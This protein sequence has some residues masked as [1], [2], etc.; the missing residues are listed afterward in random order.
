LDLNG[1]MAAADEYESML[2]SEIKKARN[3]ITAVEDILNGRNETDHICLKRTQAAKSLGVTV[4]TLRNW[5]LNG[6]VTIK[7]KENNYRVYD[8]SDMRLLNIIRTLRCANYSLSSILRLISCMNNKQP[9]DLERILNTPSLNE[10]IV[11]VC[12][13]LVISLQNTLKDAVKIKSMIREK[14]SDP[15]T[16]Q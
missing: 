9:M 3:A 12:D 8:E 4:D 11:S 10:D 5:E 13:R 15:Q 1:A 7:R 6:L 14:I 2:L 16:L